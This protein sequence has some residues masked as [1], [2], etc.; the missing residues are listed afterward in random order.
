MNINNR[1]TQYNSIKTS[2]SE[3]SHS[4]S[5]NKAISVNKKDPNYNKKT[6]SIFKSFVESFFRD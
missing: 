3:F 5:A 2:T 1:T 4:N 6:Q